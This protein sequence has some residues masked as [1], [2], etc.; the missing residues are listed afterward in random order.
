VE[1][2]LKRMAIPLIPSY[3]NPQSNKRVIQFLLGELLK[4]FQDDKE[5]YKQEEL[6]D[7]IKLL[8]E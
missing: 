5:A 7:L 4:C 2:Y 8:G 6:R 1:G 3:F